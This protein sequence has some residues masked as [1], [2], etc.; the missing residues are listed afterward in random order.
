MLLT[1]LRLLLLRQ[2]SVDLLHGCCKQVAET[3]LFYLPR[4]ELIANGLSNISDYWPG[5]LA[6]AFSVVIVDL[7]ERAFSNAK[8]M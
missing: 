4:M 8:I 5:M 2:T 6:T 3:H 7:C 1:V